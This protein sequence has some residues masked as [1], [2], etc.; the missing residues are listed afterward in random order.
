M[1]SVYKPPTGE[2]SSYQ[3]F[4]PSARLQNRLVLSVNMSTCASVYKPPTNGH[5]N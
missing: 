2:H 5:S 4:I 1:A 3:C